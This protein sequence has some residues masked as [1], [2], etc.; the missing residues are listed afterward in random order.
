[1][2]FSFQTTLFIMKG[3]SPPD[4][5]REECVPVQISSYC[6]SCSSEHPKSCSQIIQSPLDLYPAPHGS[7]SYS[8]LSENVQERRQ[9]LLS[10]ERGTKLREKPIIVGQKLENNLG[11]KRAL[12][13]GISYQQCTASLHPQISG[14]ISW[15]FQ[16]KDSFGNFLKAAGFC[17][18]NM[19]FI[20]TLHKPETEHQNIKTPAQTGGEQW[21]LCLLLHSAQLKPPKQKSFS[22]FEG[23]A[24]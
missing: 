24:S 17:H 10:S 19:K 18:R 23:E 14:R 4:S 22:C 11:W 20:T 8:K 3:G 6:N 7:R 13:Y 12:K 9:L 21:D 15:N 1:M 5:L 16:Q 2:V